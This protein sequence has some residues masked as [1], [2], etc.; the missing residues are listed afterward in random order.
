M[1][2]PCMHVQ[3]KVNIFDRNGRLYDEVPLPQSEVQLS[4]SGSP[5][6]LE[7]QVCGRIISVSGDASE[8]AILNL[9]TLT[10][11]PSVGSGD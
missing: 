11:P 7:L 6:C 5:S 8:P 10:L 1:S 2:R 3:R 9:G 4:D